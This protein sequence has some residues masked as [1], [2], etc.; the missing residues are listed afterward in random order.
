VVSRRSFLA[1]AGSVTAATALSPFSPLA[2]RAAAA[3]VSLPVKL[4][5]NSG[6]NTVYAYISGTDSSGW[7]VFVSPNG[8]LNRLPN[9]S[10]PVTPIADYSIALGASGS[11]GTTVNLT[12]Y[13]IGGQV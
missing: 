1:A 2:S 9:P 10:S 13:I 7:P 5:N 12:N 6:Q 11:A 8:A 3:G 4:T